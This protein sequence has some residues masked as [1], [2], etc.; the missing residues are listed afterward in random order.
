MAYPA[1]RSRF[2]GLGGILDPFQGHWGSPRFAAICTNTALRT[3]QA[4]KGI[5][6]HS[7]NF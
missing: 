2:T 6:A 1:F 3:D 5:R 4:G 7:L